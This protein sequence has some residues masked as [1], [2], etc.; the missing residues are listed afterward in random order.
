MRLTNIKNKVIKIDGE[1]A[2][3]D[4][5]K[6]ITLTF[7]QG[8]YSHDSITLDVSGDLK[9]IY[10]YQFDGDRTETPG[11]KYLK[12]FTTSLIGDYNNDTNIDVID[13][14]ALINALESKDT[15]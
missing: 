8:F 7:E 15:N 4:L 12:T 5:T 11:G 2:Y 14:V 6:S 1:N 10:G 3:D 9:S 13:L